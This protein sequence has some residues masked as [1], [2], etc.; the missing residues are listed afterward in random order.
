MPSFKV[1]QKRARRSMLYKAKRKANNIR[2]VRRREEEASKLNQQ[3][4]MQVIDW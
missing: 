2:Q 3:E 1:Q 4:M